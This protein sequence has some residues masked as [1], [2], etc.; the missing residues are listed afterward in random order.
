MKLPVYTSEV[1]LRSQ[2]TGPTASPAA[3]AAPA[4]Q[5]ER[6]GR[7]LLDTGAYYLRRQIEHEAVADA[8]KRTA[9]ARVDLTKILMDSQAAAPEGAPGFTAGFRQAVD[10]YSQKALANTPEMTRPYLERRLSLIQ[11]TLE[12]HAMAFEAKANL[13][14]R[15]KD[16][17]D[18]VNLQANVVRSDPTQWEGS[19]G[20]AMG[21]LHG[22]GMPAAQ[23]R[24]AEGN[25][26]NTMASSL[27]EGWNDRDP[28]QAKA[29]LDGG[30]LDTYLAPHAKNALVERNAAILTRTGNEAAAS[31]RA[32]VKGAY[33]NEVAAIRDRG[34]GTGSPFLSAATVKQAFPDQAADLLKNLGDE[35]SFYNARQTVALNAPA[36]DQALVAHYEPAAQAGGESD[37]ALAAARRD[38]L[39]KAIAAKW[40]TVTKDPV[41]YAV[42]ASPAL[43][44]AF[45]AAQGDP[46]KLGDAL[47]LSEQLQAKLGLPSYA[48]S[49]LSNGQAQ[50]LVGKLTTVPP[51]EAGQMMTGLAAQYGDRWPRA[52]ED[53]VAAK[54]PS[55]YQ[56]LGSVADPAA[57]TQLTEAFRAGRKTLEDVVGKPNTDTI[58]K[59]L[60]DA[61][62]PF[63]RTLAAA[64]NGP[65]LGQAWR[66]STELL[67]Y[68]Y[69][70]LGA[71]PAD[72]L[73]RA[74][75]DLVNSRYDFAQGAGFNARAPKGTLAPVESF[76][77]TLLGGLKAGDVQTPP[78]GAGEV[79]MTD[80]QRSAAYFRDGVA[81]N[82][83]W[84]TSPRDDGWLLLD[85]NRQPV[86]RQDGG[87]VGFTFDQ[88][89]H[90]PPPPPVDPNAVMQP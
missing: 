57:R 78:R 87:A 52:F 65:D 70:N 24:T 58:K 2:P 3:F 16:L 88:A 77:Q 84:I 60:D 12:D 5:G 80:A 4:A 81:G 85:A 89:M 8:G 90:A 13:E 29:L 56:V 82:S 37:Y 62:S 7:D 55:A 11:S 71:S 69:T 43:K 21:A 74:T 32:T 63:M 22:S 39:S 48:Q 73:K 27:I 76:A 25:I 61:L 50:D 10:D 18:T 34:Y 9:Q 42:Q 31:L 64:P 68:R 75:D 40:Q 53:L 33:D 14:K 38:A 59:G 26:K 79:E 44:S 49:V 83:Q 66:S 41:G 15:S 45:D 35:R 6:V 20:E 17:D 46:A 36:E 28:A 1:E 30:T 23:L 54:L 67:A 51:A 72:A 19:L 86:R 47:A